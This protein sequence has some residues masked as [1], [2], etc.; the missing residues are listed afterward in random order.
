MALL[1][2]VHWVAKQEGATSAEQALEKYTT[3]PSQK[4]ME[5][6]SAHVSETITSLSIGK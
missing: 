6:D 2:S 4:A 1:A 3:G 5:C